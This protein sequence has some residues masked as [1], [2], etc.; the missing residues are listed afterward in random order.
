MRAS[1]STG[2]WAVA[3]FSGGVALLAL[4]ALPFTAWL[5][6][7][8][9]FRQTAFAVVVVLAACALVAVVALDLL[10][11]GDDTRSGLTGSAD[12]S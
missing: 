8:E 9:T 3:S 5:G 1:V 2:R 11:V 7:G 12:N 4:A 6:D 10:G